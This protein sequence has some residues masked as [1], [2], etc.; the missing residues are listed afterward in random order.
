MS[1]SPRRP[2]PTPPGESLAVALFGG[3]LAFVGTL[4]FLVWWE[5]GYTLLL[6]FPLAC[7]VA[8]LFLVAR[9]K[10]RDYEIYLSMFPPEPEP[11]P[12]P[13]PNPIIQPVTV[14]THGLGQILTYAQFKL[15]LS[16]WQRLARVLLKSEQITREYIAAADVKDKSFDHLTKAYPSIKNRMVQAGWFTGKGELTEVGKQHFEQFLKPHQTPSQKL[17]SH[18]PTPQD[19][20]ITANIVETT[21]TTTANGGAS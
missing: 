2:R 1:V 6:A 13:Q 19:N 7:L 18:L 8:L 21:T 15:P 16:D 20:Y 12:E 9:L 5:Y 10:Q 4:F 3:I 11:E 14:N 17:P